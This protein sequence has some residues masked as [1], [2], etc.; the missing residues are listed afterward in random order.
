MSLNLPSTTTL[1][2]IFAM[3]LLFN[4]LWMSYLPTTVGIHYIIDV[5]HVNPK[6]IYDNAALTYI[7]DKTLEAADVTI[8]NKAQHAF[9]P[10]GLTLLYLLTESHFSLHTWPE[11]GKLRIDFFSCQNHDK[12]EKGYAYLREA[13]RG[14]TIQANK[15]YR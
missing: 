9:E 1:I 4:L 11:H 14:A 6:L 7:C 8:V 15:L 3:I 13:F 2:T 10:H 12:C 5:D